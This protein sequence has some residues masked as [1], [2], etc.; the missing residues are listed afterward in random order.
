MG[1]A[2]PSRAAAVESVDVTPVMNMFIILIPFLVSMAVFSHLSVIEFTLPPDGGTGRIADPETLPLTVA[3]TDDE[4]ALARGE[5][6]LA[7]VEKVDGLFDFAALAAVLGRLGPPAA[8]ARV[9]IAIDDAVLFADIVD[10]MDTCR[11][12]GYADVGLA[13]GTNLDRTGETG[14]GPGGRDADR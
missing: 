13:A 8:E 4:L 5:T 9:V 3:M 6:I 10:C 1:L 12:A 7:A 11:L 2:T 14:P